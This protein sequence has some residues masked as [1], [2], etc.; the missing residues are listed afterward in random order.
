MTTIGG[1]YKGYWKDDKME[2]KGKLIFA[3][4]AVYVGNFSNGK[5]RMNLRLDLIIFSFFFCG[6]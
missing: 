4:G 5:P 2:S 6:F 1:V 3:S